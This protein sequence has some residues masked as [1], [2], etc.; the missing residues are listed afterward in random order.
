MTLGQFALGVLAQSLAL[1]ARIGFANPLPRFAW[2][3][4]AGA[5]GTAAVSPAAMALAIASKGWRVLRHTTL[6]LLYEEAVRPSFRHWLVL[7]TRFR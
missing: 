1:V 7:R 2:L 3:A 5:A 4:L 6:S